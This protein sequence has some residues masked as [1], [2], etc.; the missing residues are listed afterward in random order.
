[1]S[2]EDVHLI[3]FSLGAHVS[4]FAGHWL[5][6]LGRITGNYAIA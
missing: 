6:G 5:D 2:L 1:M 3:G 4:G